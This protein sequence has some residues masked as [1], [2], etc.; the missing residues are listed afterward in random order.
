MCTNSS[1]V[2][3]AFIPFIP[4]N[5]TVSSGVYDPSISY[6]FYRAAGDFIEIK[7]QLFIFNLTIMPGIQSFT[8]DISNLPYSLISTGTEY[9]IG[10]G[11]PMIYVVFGADKVSS[12][13]DQVFGFTGVDGYASSSTTIHFDIAWDD[14]SNSTSHDI[15]FNGEFD[16]R[17][18]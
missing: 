14:S 17:F 10:F 15:Y 8:I 11:T 7:M 18:T 5:V 13:V 12:D 3:F 9:G 1:Q 16:G 2:L 4:E 6:Y